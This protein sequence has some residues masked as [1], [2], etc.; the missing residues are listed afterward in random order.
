MPMQPN[1][2]YQQQMMMQQMQ[3]QQLQQMQMQMQMQQQQQYQQQIMMQMAA[4]NSIKSGTI[5]QIYSLKGTTSANP[6]VHE[7]ED[8][9]MEEAS[10]GKQTPREPSRPG[11]EDGD[12]YID[13]DAIEC[14]PYYTLLTLR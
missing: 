10:T 7:D 6:S 5:N 3:M 14:N 13:D 12:D 1:P 4:Q 11:T 9:E 8:A 2:Q